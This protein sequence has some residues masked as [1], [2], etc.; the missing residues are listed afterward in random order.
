MKPKI[1]VCDDEEGVRESFRLILGQDYDLVFASNGEEGVKIVQN[2]PVEL[3]L[4]DIKMPRKNGIDALKEMKAAREDLAVIMSTGYRSVEVAQE[5][6]RH[7]ATEYVLKPF[8]RQKI[9]ALVK[10]LLD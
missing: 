1:L 9:Q 8:D 3:V 2:Q 4:L 5:A 7:G 6:S 10:K